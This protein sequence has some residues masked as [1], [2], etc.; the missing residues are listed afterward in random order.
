MGAIEAQALLPAEDFQREADSS[1]NWLGK[2]A[3]SLATAAPSSSATPDWLSDVEQET[4]GQPSVPPPIP[5]ALPGTPASPAKDATKRRPKVQV[6]EAVPLI[7]E[8]VFEQPRVVSAVLYPP[9]LILSGASARRQGGERGESRFQTWLWNGNDTA[10][11]HEV[12]LLIVAYGRGSSQGSEEASKLTVQTVAQHLS[13]VRLSGQLDG[14]VMGAVI[15]QTFHEANRVIRDKAKGDPGWDGMNATAA[16]VVIWNG[17]AHFGHIGDCQVY[18]HR[19][20]ELKQ[21]SKDHPQK[22]SSKEGTQTL[23]TGLTIKPAR[24]SHELERGDSLLVSAHSLAAHLALPGMKQVLNSP[25]CPPQHLALPLVS[26][27]EEAGGR[28]TCTL[29]VAH[30]S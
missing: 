27:A 5:P 22:E 29:V 24:G 11:S 8:P 21:L 13:P 2:V 4:V 17:Q 20:K 10:R 7:A 19:G 12:A 15:D 9:R 1:G 26:L 6:V 30:F 18:L 3:K 14:S 23:G 25:P 28:E 16:V